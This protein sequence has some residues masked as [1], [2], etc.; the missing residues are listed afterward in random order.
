MLDPQGRVLGHQA[1]GLGAHR[2]ALL[3]QGLGARTL[4]GAGDRR[5][6][7]LCQGTGGGPGRG[8]QE[9]GD[10]GGGQGETRHGGGIR[11]G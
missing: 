6:D 11:S 10:E 1:I 3:A 9:G 5:G 2:M 7:G 8:G 4:I